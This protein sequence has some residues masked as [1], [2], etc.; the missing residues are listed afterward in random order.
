MY[1]YSPEFINFS[2]RKI[3][4]TFTYKNCLISDEQFLLSLNIEDIGDLGLLG[5]YITMPSH[6][7]ILRVKTKY[8][9]Y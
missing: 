3:K 7:G 8:I 5:M 4:S 2:K 1:F 6:N 9:I